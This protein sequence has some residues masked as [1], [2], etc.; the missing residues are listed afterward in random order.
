MPSTDVFRDP[1]D[2]YGRAKIGA[3]VTDSMR[4]Q[5][6]PA[7]AW[8]VPQE[9]DDL[10]M[11]QQDIKSAKVFTEGQLERLRR[12]IESGRRNDAVVQCKRDYGLGHTPEK[13][14][15]KGQALVDECEQELA[16]LDFEITRLLWAEMYP[17]A[18]APV[19]YDL[20][21]HRELHEGK[22]PLDFDHHWHL[23]SELWCE[24]CDYF[25]DRGFEVNAEILT[26]IDKR[27]GLGGFCQFVYRLREGDMKEAQRYCD[28]VTDEERRGVGDCHN[29]LMMRRGTGGSPVIV[30]DQPGNPDYIPPLVMQSRVR[31][32]VHRRFGARRRES[33]GSKPSRRRGSR[34]VTSRSSGGGSSGDDPDP[35]PLARTGAYGLA[36]DRMLWD[37]A[38]TSFGALIG[39]GV[40]GL[41]GKLVG[42]VV[43]YLWGRW[44]WHR[45]ATRM[46]RG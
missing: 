7:A 16:E 8:K 24:F 5:P 4:R 1:R 20:N 19:D 28:L 41:E 37:I 25:A 40:M 31:A 27:I 6:P 30:I 35:E 14:I 21:E 17:D 2:P 9:I 44:R 36:E 34:R 39:D 43:A 15:A 12:Q 26:S 10:Q 32:F 42:G 18:P 11:A 38:V 22:N 29:R 3:Q 46:R 23:M 13:A 33:Q 45:R